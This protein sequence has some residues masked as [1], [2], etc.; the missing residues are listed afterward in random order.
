MR[1]SAKA[2][3]GPLFTGPGGC[4]FL[5]FAIWSKEGLTG[6]YRSMLRPNSLWGAQ[7]KIKEPVVLS[8]VRVKNS[9]KPWC[10]VVLMNGIER[11]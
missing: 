5:N 3:S 8:G 6:Q 10:R 9:P 7:S 11:L 4:C 1:A 2:K